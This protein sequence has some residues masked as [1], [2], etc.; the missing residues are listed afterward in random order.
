M[1]VPIIERTYDKISSYLVKTRD[2]T[3]VSYNRF[4]TGAENSED[5]PPPTSII[6]PPFDENDNEFKIFRGYHCQKGA[7]LCSVFGMS[8][9]ILMFTTTFFE[10][11]WYHHE[12]GVDFMTLLGLILYLVCGILIHY[13]IIY[14]CKKQQTI[15]FFPFIVIYMFLILSEA[16]SLFTVVISFI[17]FINARNN[18]HPEHHQH[19]YEILMYDHTKNSV[20]I[21]SI[22]LLPLITV[23]SIM[24][25][26][27]LK[28]RNYI[29]A[30]NA[31]AAALRVA[32]RAKQQ[33]PDIEIIHGPTKYNP[34]Q[35]DLESA[36]SQ[37][38]ND[39]NT[40]QQIPSSFDPQ[41]IEEE[42]YKN[43]D[44]KNDKY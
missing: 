42:V 32:E 29:A 5:V 7:L 14:G 6:V 37:T 21:S 27:V 3:S 24:I 44:K 35:R 1:K 34:S 38:H 23:Q 10:F 20:I 36:V 30:K 22:V 2:A 18:S 41:E 26:I 16:L 31:H 39:N 43:D 9:I 19:Y 4:D 8:F 12:R 17:Y 15:Y 33:Y 25:Y 13:F 40:Q 11:D 28:C